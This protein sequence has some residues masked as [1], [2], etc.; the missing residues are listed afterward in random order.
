[1]PHTQPH[2]HINQSPHPF[3][4]YIKPTLSDQIQIMNTNNKYLAEE[5][6]GRINKVMDFIELNLD[7]SYTLEELAEVASFS[8]FHFSRIF[9]AMRGETPFVFL[10]R[11]RMEKAASLL[12]MNPKETISEIA[13]QCG[14][15]SLPVFSRKFIAHFDCT[16]MSWRDGQKESNQSQTQ[17]QHC[18]PNLIVISK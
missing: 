17:C 7:K 12:I 4:A 10:N 6:Q 13:Y 1:M 2:H 18:P 3:F 14:F 15:S 8:K 9:W 11:I 16:A 5:Y